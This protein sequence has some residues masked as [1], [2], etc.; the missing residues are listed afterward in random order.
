MADS[1]ACTC[2][3]C[4]I[5]EES[6]T[7]SR[8]RCACC[9]KTAGG[10]TPRMKRCSKC[11]A[12]YYCSHECQQSDWK[13]HKKT[14]SPPS[15]RRS[16]ETTPPTSGSNG[17]TLSSSRSNGTTP[18]PTT[19]NTPVPAPTSKALEAHIAKP[20]TRLD[21]HTY[22][23]GRTDK[24]VFKLLVDCFRL[25]QTDNR[26]FEGI[27]PSDSIDGIYAH[28]HNF[29]CRAV[30]LPVGLLPPSWNA[31]KLDECESFG[32]SAEG[33]ADFSN[34]RRGPVG[35]RDIVEHYGDAWMPIQ[36]RMLGQ[37]VYQKGPGCYD[38]TNLRRL[39]VQSE[40]F[41]DAE[42]AGEQIIMVSLHRRR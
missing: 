15:T 11:S 41:D 8:N 4:R 13:L 18:R 6:E 22:L 25:R 40:I 42:A 34:L 14:C 26:N 28:F 23:H 37:T 1:E 35:R 7:P 30:A 39:L 16:N 19:N 20:F 3:F 2:I 36:L 24:D 27:A 5:S 32:L 12:T 33:D 31:A 29:L 9:K 38:S 17:P 10:E 21:N